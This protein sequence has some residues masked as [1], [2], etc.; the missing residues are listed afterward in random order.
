MRGSHSAVRVWGRPLESSIES[1]AGASGASLEALLSEFTAQ[2]GFDLRTDFLSWMEDFR[3]YVRG[4]GLL[5]LGGAVSIGSSDPE[6][7][8]ETVEQLMAL[9]L[10]EGFPSQSLEIAGIESYAISIPGTPQP[11]VVVPGDRV[12]VAYGEAAAEDALDPEEPLSGSESFASAMEK[13]GDGM[14]AYFYLDIDSVQ[15]LVE[16][17]L[18]PVEVYVDEVKPWLDPI[19]HVIA[20]SKF[21]DDSY[22]VRFVIGVE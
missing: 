12:V 15:G 2:T 14:D 1:F 5:D 16:N 11:I 17:F 20:G 22:L 19:A 8:R 18:P 13:L 4:T 10:Q 3:V 9:A 6:A 7:S 21:S